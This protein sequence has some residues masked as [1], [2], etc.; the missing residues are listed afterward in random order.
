MLHFS[1]NKIVDSVHA[2]LG[3]GLDCLIRV[4]GQPGKNLI[5]NK[6]ES[7]NKTKQFRKSVL[8]VKYR[9]IIFENVENRL[10]IQLKN[11]SE[12]YLRSILSN[13]IRFE[14]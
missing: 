13:Y 10:I 6:T 2:T 8:N 4:Q 12:I 9:L 1:F 3:L 5:E 11:H 14:K 7:T